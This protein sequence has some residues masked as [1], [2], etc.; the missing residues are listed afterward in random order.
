MRAEGLQPSD[1]AT[2]AALADRDAG[3]SVEQMDV[4]RL[5]AE[6][7]DATFGRPLARAHPRHSLERGAVR[8]R[9]QKAVE[10]WA[11]TAAR[12]RVAASVFGS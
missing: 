7:D 8:A 9:Q 4:R 5:D 6:P 10:G 11:A 1:W 3:P 2:G 12:L